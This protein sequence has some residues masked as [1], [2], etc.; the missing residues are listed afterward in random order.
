MMAGM[1]STVL[2]V[3]LAC[4]ASC[5]FNAGIAVQA[6][7]VRQVPTEEGVRLSL[8]TTL[9]KRPRWLLGT[10]LNVLALPVQTVALLLAPLTAVQPADATGLLL[11]LFLGSRVLGERVGLVEIGAVVAIVGGIVI[12][13]LS[14]PHRAVTHVGAADVLVPLLVVAAAALLPIVLRSFVGPDSI[15]V[16]IGAGSAFALT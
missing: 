1:S 14:A 5:L 11:L 2:G 6:G 9:L 8:L 15:V 10:G 12:L 7:E 16:V 3:A 4:L 13:T